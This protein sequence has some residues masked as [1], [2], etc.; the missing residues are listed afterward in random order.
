MVCYK[1]YC[2]LIVFTCIFTSCSKTV[3]IDD[4]NYPFDE[5]D[6]IINSYK[7][8]TIFPIKKLTVV[9]KMELRSEKRKLKSQIRDKNKQIKCMTKCGCVKGSGYNPEDLKALRKQIKS[10]SIT[11]D[12]IRTVLDK[13]SEL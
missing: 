13:Q 10:L 4:I 2:Y 11:V 9:E 6:S 3:N 8:D 1:K 7:K 12:S 5:I